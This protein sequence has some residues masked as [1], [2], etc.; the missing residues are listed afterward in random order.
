MASGRREA[1]FCAYFNLA[2]EGASVRRQLAEIVRLRPVHERGGQD[3]IVPVEYDHGAVIRWWW[4]HHS[5]ISV[6]DGFRIYEHDCIIFVVMKVSRN[7]STLMCR[8][9][10]DILNRSVK[11]IAAVRSHRIF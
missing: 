6:R 11:I 7:R 4:S 8:F 5:L 3:G 9:A 1:F 10:V 2:K